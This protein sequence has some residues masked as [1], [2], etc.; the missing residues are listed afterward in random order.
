MDHKGKTFWFTQKAP[1]DVTVEQ[2]YGDRKSVARS[3]QQVSVMDFVFIPDT[4]G[5]YNY[6]PELSDPTL[7]WGGNMKFLSSTASNLVEEN[8]EFIEFWMNVRTAPDSAK[9]YIDL[10]RISEDVIP[11]NRLDTEDIFNNETITNPEIQDLGL[12][13]LTDAEEQAEYNSTRPDPAGDN[14]FFQRNDAIHPF[15]YFNI[16][17]TQGNAVLTDIGLIP[18]TEDLNR[19]GTLDQVNSYFR[20]EIPLDTNRETNPFH[21]RRRS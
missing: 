4:P 2:I 1:S 11:N 15:D 3:D 7:S 13:M 6:T 8:V 19:N 17:G 14:F 9:L 20:Y 18:D 5:T 12:D 16:N 21:C 10:G